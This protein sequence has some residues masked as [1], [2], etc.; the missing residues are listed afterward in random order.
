[1]AKPR[2]FKKTGVN[3]LK[4]DKKTGVE[5]ITAFYF[6]YLPIVSILVVVLYAFFP[7]IYQSIGPVS[8]ISQKPFELVGMGIMFFALAWVVIA[9]SQMGAS[10]RIGVDHDEETAFIQKGLFRYSR[11]PI[12][13][14]M[15]FLV[16]GFFLVLP[17]PL[18]LTML[19]LD[20]ALI[21]IHF[22]F[23]L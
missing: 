23:F 6:K 12:Y 8:L 13:V 3:A 19:A 7:S 9:Q 14:G 18:T 22:D 20:I 2:G 11:N 10:W 21:K 16:F 1:L 4:L 17:N 5:V 15:I